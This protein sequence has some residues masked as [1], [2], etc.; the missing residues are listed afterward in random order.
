MCNSCGKK[1][2][3]VAACRSKKT[4]KPATTSYVVDATEDDMEIDTI[5]NNKN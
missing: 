4:K 1:G 3:L 5:E 2:H